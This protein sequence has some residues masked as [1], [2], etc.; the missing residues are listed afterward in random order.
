MSDSN[1]IGWG[2]F[3]GLFAFFIIL[4][5]AILGGCL[6]LGLVGHQS[7]KGLQQAEQQ[8]RISDETLARAKLE[9]QKQ[10]QAAERAAESEKW[11]KALKAREEQEAEQARLERAKQ[12]ENLFALRKQR[13]LSGAPDACF[14]LG[15][16]YV[17]GE[18]T[19]TNL[20]LGLKYIKIAAQNGYGSAVEYLKKVGPAQDEASK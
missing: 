10:K 14:D 11:R 18:G 2:I 20:D 4:P 6:V 5:L 17:K 16:M 7:S 8:K 15:M 13:A 19:E 9:M 12:L 1:S 3:K